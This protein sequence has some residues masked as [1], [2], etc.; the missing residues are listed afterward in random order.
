M[1]EVER[2]SRS[3]GAL[4]AV[5]RL[6]FGIARGEV[7]G[8]LGPNGAGKTTTMRLL[9]TY[10]EPSGGRATLA[11]FDVVTQA[12]AVRS[13]VGYLPEGVP[14][15]DELRVR[16]FLDFRA[17]LKD[18]PRDRRRAAV[19]GVLAACGLED[20]AER[21]IGALSRGYRQ[22]VGLADALVHDPDIVI[23][24]EPTGGLD[25]IQIREVRALI[26]DLGARHTVLLST[27]I[28]PEVEAVCDRV[29][30]IAG[31]R[32]ALDDR[33]DRLRAETAMT[34]EAAGPA[35]AIGRALEAMPGVGSVRLRGES[36]GAATFEVR[37]ADG[38]DLREALA[39]RVV[40]NGWG[41]RRL[42]WQR[43]TLEDRYVEAVRAAGRRGPRGG[44]E[45]P[46]R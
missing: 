16:A 27:H 6:S 29:I 3:F 1:I 7:V 10:L 35:D 36:A 37:A 20:A 22:R 9:T 28:L 15:Y 4:R 23:L 8:L 32:I 5:D 43:S 33:L 12:R 44:A 24:D 19:D 31:G 26:R 21:P 42:D 39:R 14:L 13:R 45:H 34:V 30:L 11:G 25:P 46:E 38:G 40:Q 17:R 41:L 2:L 18:V